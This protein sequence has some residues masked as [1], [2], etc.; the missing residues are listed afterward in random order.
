M[1]TLLGFTKFDAELLVTYDHEASKRLGK[2]YWRV[3]KGFRYYLGTKGSNQWIDVPAGYLTD[4]A[5]V[6]RAFW[7]IIPPWGAYGQAAVVH[8]M[9]CEYLSITVDGLPKR[10]SRPQADLV[11]L[12]AMK[13]LEV[14]ETTAYTIYNAVKLYQITFNV[15]EPSNDPAKREQ[16]SLW[17]QRQLTA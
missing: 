12:E 9:L 14:P 15:T 17:A 3:M 8:D 4:G 2:D 6:P 11:L 13:V 7:S 16:E 1:T 10:I 5:S